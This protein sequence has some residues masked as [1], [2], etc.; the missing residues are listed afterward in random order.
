MKT[1]SIAQIAEMTGSSEGTLRQHA[2]RGHLRT[3]KQG[4][5]SV[6]TQPDLDAYLSA[7]ALV[8]TVPKVRATNADVPREIGNMIAR[9]PKAVGDAILEGLPTT[10]RAGS[11]EAYRKAVAKLPQYPAVADS[12]DVHWGYPI[13]YQHKTAPRWKRVSES[14]WNL[15][16][17]SWSWNG[18]EWEGGGSRDN[19]P[20]LGDGVSPA[21]P[22]ADQRPLAMSKKVD[23]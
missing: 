11:G 1:Y 16:G 20:P 15:D 14:T 18:F 2:S 3:M 5:R 7:E 17:A 13:G 23:K 12:G 8:A 19:V 21:S 9:L 6:V 4:T 10:K 22:Y